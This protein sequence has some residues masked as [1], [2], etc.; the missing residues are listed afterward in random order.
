MPS[1]G[2]GDLV[3]L[4]LEDLLDVKVYAASKFVHDVAHAPASVTIVTADEI[5]THGY[6]TLADALRSVRGF[7]VTYDRNYSY[8]G[9]RGFS[10]PGDFNSRVLLLVNGHRLNDNIFEQ[11]LLGTES[12]LDLALVERI[13][14]IRGPSSS[15]YGTSAFLAVVNIITRAGRSLHG[16]EVEGRSGSQLLRS[17]RFTVGGRGANGFEG[18]L[19]VSALASAGNRR[20]YFPEFSDDPGGGAARNADGDNAVT[21]Y[22]NAAGRGLNLQVGIGTRSKTIP[23]AAFGTVFND[24]RTSTRD[25]R[26]FFDLRYTRRLGH[27]TTLEARGSYD[28][29]RYDGKYAYEEGLFVDHA[30]GSWLTAEVAVVRQFDRHALTTGLESRT[31]L[32]QDQRAFDQAGVLLDDRRNSRTAALYVED[33]VR[34]APNLLVNAGLRWDRYFETFG[35]TVNPRLGVIVTPWSGSALK[36]LYGRAFRAPNPFELYYDQ[37]ARSARLSPERIATQEVAWEQGLSKRVRVIALGFQNSVDGLIG[38]ASGSDTLDGLYYANGGS[39]EATGVEFEVQ[40]DVPGAAHFRLTHAFQSVV[41]AATRERLSNSP[42]SISRAVL[43]VPIARTRWVAAVDAAFVGDRRSVSG[44][45][46][47]G[48]FVADLT[49]SRA[50]SARGLGVA[51]TLRNL[52]GTDYAD[53][54]SVEHRQATIPQD[55]PTLDF[56]ATWRF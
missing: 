9:V 7:Y 34:L 42:R 22:G 56:R 47:P 50:P 8:L 4:P 10:R 3:D 30:V 33:E 53:P 44:A 15:L 39:A 55:G 24:T 25:R 19:S 37:N 29:Y 36:L 54:G 48:A 5:R 41:D 23:T 27:R 38:Q 2:G 49:V 32:R 16:V 18:L 35:G 21:V 14:V 31:N 45:E 6:R 12:P 46:V 13:E 52:F 40:A 26:S 1:R 17:G 20:L 11:A 28:R 43:D 51:A